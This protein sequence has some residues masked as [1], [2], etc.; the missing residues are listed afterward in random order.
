MISYPGKNESKNSEHRKTY[1]AKKVLNARCLMRTRFPHSNGFRKPA[2][3]DEKQ[4][5]EIISGFLV[6]P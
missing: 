6:D 2:S 1:K 5:Q 3:G 4:N